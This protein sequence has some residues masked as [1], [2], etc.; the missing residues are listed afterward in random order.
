VTYFPNSIEGDVA[1][2]VHMQTNLRK[3][4]QEGPRYPVFGTKLYAEKLQAGG[5]FV[6]KPGTVSWRSKVPPLTSKMNSCGKA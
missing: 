3:H 6:L 1:N 4:Q 5:T 2:L